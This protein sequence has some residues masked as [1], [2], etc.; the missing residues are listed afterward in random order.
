MYPRCT[1]STSFHLS[2]RYSATRRRWRL[3]GFSSLHKRHPA[4]RTSRDTRS[5]IF[6]IHQIE[7]FILIDL[8]VPL[9]LL[10]RVQNVRCG[11]EIKQVLVIYLANRSRE[12]S[13]IIPLRK[14]CKLRNVIQPNVQESF[15]L[16]FME[17]CKKRLRRLF[18][19]PN[20]EN[21]YFVALP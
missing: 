10:V 21:L 7:K 17:K 9:V 6:L 11:C 5:S 13:Q 14:A 18:R 8:P 12:I 15:Y 1:I 20:R 2:L 3:W 4:F 16:R 19:K